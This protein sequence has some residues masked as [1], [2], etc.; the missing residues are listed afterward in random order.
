MRISYP[1][2]SRW[3]AKECRKVWQLTRRE[4]PSVDD[5]LMQ[6]A[7]DGGLVQVMAAFDLGAGVD[8]DVL[9]GE[10]E[11]PSPIALGAG[12]LSRESVRQ[13]DAA[14]AVREIRDVDASDAGEPVRE[15]RAHDGRKRHDAV[16][17][18][19]GVAD[20]DAVVAEL[21]VLDAQAQAP[22]A[23]AC[24]CRREGSRRA[25]ACRACL[26][27]TERTSA[28]VRTVGRRPGR[29]ARMTVSMVGEL[30]LE[31]VPVEKEEGAQG[32]GLGRRADGALDGE[33]GDEGVDLG[34]AHLERDGAC[35]ERGCSGG[36]SRHRP[37]RCAG[38]SDARG[39]R[40][41]RGRAGGAGR[42][43][44]VGGV[45]E[46]GGR[47]GMRRAIC[48]REPVSASTRELRLLVHKSHNQDAVAD[49]VEEAVRKSP[50]ESPP[51]G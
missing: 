48:R 11:L 5:G 44:G 40:G 17:V 3:V 39:W 33:V 10:D 1:S 15:S 28:R 16:A 18:A 36:S 47:V 4:M 22:R 12:V 45:A 51:D 6:G 25:W 19:L 9:A 50:Q 43:G 32:L 27:M 41:G 30:L 13:E 24:R 37:P 42:G 31:D 46:P 29:F 35:R 49:F 14:E 38:C 8:A 20:E 23:G 2:S 7:L 34:L 21:D 26:P